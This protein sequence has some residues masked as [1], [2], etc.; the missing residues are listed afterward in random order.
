MKDT[1]VLLKTSGGDDIGFGVLAG[2]SQDSHTLQ[3]LIS[4]YEL[5]VKY[6]QPRPGGDVL[7]IPNIMDITLPPRRALTY[8]D[9]QGYNLSIQVPVGSYLITRYRIT[10]SQNFVQVDQSVQAGPQLHFVA[11]LPAPGIEFLRVALQ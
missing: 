10:D 6:R 2:R 1:P 11:S 9:D 8:S 3:V 7:R 5:P 4:N